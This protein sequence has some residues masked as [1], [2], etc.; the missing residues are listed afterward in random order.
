MLRREDPDARNIASLALALQ[1]N[2]PAAL[3]NTGEPLVQQIQYR[4]YTHPPPCGNGWDLSARDGMCY[5]NGALPP[6]DQ[7]ARRRY[8][9]QDY[10]HRGY[11][12]REYYGGRGY[13][14]GRYP[15]PCGGDGQRQ[16]CAHG[17]H[18]NKTPRPALCSYLTR[19]ALVNRPRTF[20]LQ[21]VV[22]QRSAAQGIDILQSVVTCG[23]IC[24]GFAR[25]IHRRF[26][27]WHPRPMDRR[28]PFNLQYPVLCPYVQ[29]S[30]DRCP[31]RH[32]ASKFGLVGNRAAPR[33]QGM[34]YCRLGQHCA[35][36]A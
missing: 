34:R 29:P 15:V 25:K 31:A 16:P 7:A 21:A 33:L 13:R 6:Q 3:K 22:R 11:G 14:G 36:L 28:G 5:P 1:L 10:E 8:Y 35:E 18:A 26:P 4:G 24:D 19:S 9:R 17:R 32:P 30:G 27:A 23:I 2:S 20:P 12:D